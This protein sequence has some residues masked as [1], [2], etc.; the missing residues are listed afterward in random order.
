MVSGFFQLF[1]KFWAP[2]H[3][4]LALWM[5]A[6]LMKIWA[7]FSCTAGS[8]IIYT[9]PVH[10]W[11]KWKCTLEIDQVWIHNCILPN[12]TVRFLILSLWSYTSFFWA[13]DWYILILHKA[14]PTGDNICDSKASRS[15]MSMKKTWISLKRQSGVFKFK[16]LLCF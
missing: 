13:T 16:E 12:W 2:T 11:S 7:C 1:F 8:M 14:I 3:Y 10:Y 4:L 6:R 5:P 15:K 9:T